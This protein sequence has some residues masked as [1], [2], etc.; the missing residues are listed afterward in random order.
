MKSLIKTL[1]LSLITAISLNASQFGDIN[2]TATIEDGNLSYTNDPVY[3]G[4]WL[5]NTKGIGGFSSWYAYNDGGGDHGHSYYDIKGKFIS[6]N[7]QKDID[8]NALEVWKMGVFGK[9]VKVGFIEKQYDIKNPDINNS[10]AATFNPD[11]NM[12]NEVDFRVLK[13]FEQKEI[14]S[15]SVHGLDTTSILAAKHDDFGTAG[16]APKV[17]LYLAVVGKNGLSPETLVKTLQWFYDNGIRIVNISMGFER[18]IYY[19]GIDKAKEVIQKIREFRQKGMLIIVASGNENT[20]GV[21]FR[22]D[23]AFEKAGAIHIGSILPNGERWT[24]NDGYGSDYGEVLD[25][26]APT[27][28]Q[29]DKPLDYCNYGG[30][31]KWGNTSLNGG[32]SMSAPLIAGTI[33]LMLEVNPDLNSSEIVDILGKT[34]IKLGSE[35]FPLKSGKTYEYKTCSEGMD[36]N[37]SYDIDYIADLDKVWDSKNNIWYY[38]LPQ[39][40]YDTALCQKYSWNNELG[41]GLV[42]SEGAVREAINRIKNPD[43]AIALLQKNKKGYYHFPTA[44]LAKLGS[45]G[46]VDYTQYTNTPNTINNLIALVKSFS[47]TNWH[48]LGADKDTNPTDII[49]AGAKAVF[50]YRNGKWYAKTKESQTLPNGI[51]AL[52]TVKKGEGVWVLS[53]QHIPQTPTAVNSS[54]TDTNILLN[55]IKNINDTK[56]HLLASNKTTNANDIISNGAKIV[57]SFKNNKW[58]VK[59]KT[60]YNLPDTIGKLDNINAY[61]GV[62]V[63]K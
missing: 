22:S 18:N 35:K 39:K 47:D 44:V 58:F 51:E 11:K 2:L 26:V 57:W 24:R 43:R 20:K 13:N 30:C 54:N 41:Y 40:P 37:T 10:I 27:H 62:W 16:I 56:W 6:E 14:D 46:G 63:V 50:V 29:Y 49:N 34:A 8:M 21:T 42:D 17:K 12:S 19:Y 53:S 36:K 7:F 38:D 25:F 59:T 9:D 4:F 61:D 55:S 1:T 31:K 28:L 48:L 60:T 5:T 15:N 32:T 45:I 23:L 52:Q 3:G 33:A